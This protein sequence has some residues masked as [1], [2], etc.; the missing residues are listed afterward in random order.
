[1]HKAY[2]KQSSS[3]HQANIEQARPANI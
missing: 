3:K 1:M 2:T